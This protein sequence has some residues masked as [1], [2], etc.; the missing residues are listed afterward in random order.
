MYTYDCLI[1][2]LNCTP[3]EKINKY[4]NLVKYSKIFRGR[5]ILT[6]A[7][8]FEMHLKQ[9]G[10]RVAEKDGEMDKYELRNYSQMLGADSTY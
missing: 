5:Y 6:S 9:N 1:L 2:Y 7:I 3:K 10:L 8:Y 4:E